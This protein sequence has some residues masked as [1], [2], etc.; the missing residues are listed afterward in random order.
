MLISDVLTTMCYYD[1]SK[2]YL[3][4]QTKRRLNTIGNP[5]CGLLQ[6]RNLRIDKL[7]YTDSLTSQRL[8]RIHSSAFTFACNLQPFDLKSEKNTF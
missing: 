8:F 3:R 2:E 6:N 1:S 4:T 7:S 5:N